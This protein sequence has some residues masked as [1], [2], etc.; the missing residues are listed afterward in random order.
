METPESPNPGFSIEN[1]HK[2]PRGELQG[3]VFMMWAEDFIARRT[4]Q[5]QEQFQNTFDARWRLD[6]LHAEERFSLFLMAQSP[7]PS[8][9]RRV[10]E[11]IFRWGIDANQFIALQKSLNLEL[12]LDWGMQGEPSEDDIYILEEEIRRVEERYPQLA[13]AAHSH[14]KFIDALNLLWEERNVYDW[15]QCFW[16]FPPIEIMSMRPRIFRLYKYLCEVDDIIPKRVV[17]PPAEGEAPRQE[18]DASSPEGNPVQGEQATA[19]AKPQD[20]IET[21]TETSYKI[22]LAALLRE[23]RRYPWSEGIGLSSTAKWLS[24][25]LDALGCT[26]TEKTIGKHLAGLDD[27]IRKKGNSAI[28]KK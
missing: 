14:Q 26:M 4:A 18:D 1:V 25:K 22:L 3:P 28:S 21:R 24:G 23:I 10:S 19:A 2:V 13:A 5:M 17:M 15:A 6:A 27:A 20:D 9:A 8:G 12:F 16:G 11:Q 7:V